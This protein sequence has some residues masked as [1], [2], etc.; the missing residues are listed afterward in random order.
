MHRLIVGLGA[1]L[2]LITVSHASGVL[3]TFDDDV[4]QWVGCWEESAVTWS[5]NGGLSSGVSSGS[6]IEGG[7]AL[8]ISASGPRDHLCIGR[9]GTDQGWTPSERYSSIELDLYYPNLS[10]ITIYGHLFNGPD[11]AIYLAGDIRQ[12]G[13]EGPSLSFGSIEPIAG[14]DGWHRVAME[15]QAPDHWVNNWTHGDWFDGMLLDIWGPHQPY[16][17]DNV[18]IVPIPEPTPATLACVGLGIWIM[19]SRRRA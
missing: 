2:A 10:G 18:R 15:F 6:G 19:L 13:L 8:R 9:P 17:I 7:G 5:E 11:H 3:Y 14:H 12:G 16:I 1:V 4:Q